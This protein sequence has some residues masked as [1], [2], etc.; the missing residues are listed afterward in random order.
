[1]IAEFP[2]DF[3]ALNSGEDLFP[4]SISD[5]PWIA[6][7]GTS[8]RNESRIDEQGLQA[9]NTP[10]SEDELRAVMKVFDLMSWH[11]E[12]HDGYSVLKYWSLGFDR[13]LSSIV[14]LILE[15]MLITRKCGVGTAVRTPN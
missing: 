10:I 13:L 15:R 5:D 11:G 8:G 2:F 6:Y 3:D 9:N 4:I 7:H 1:M 12:V 14:L